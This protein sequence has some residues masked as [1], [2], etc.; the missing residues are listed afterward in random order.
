MPRRPAVHVTHRASGDWAVIREGSDRASSLHPTQ[1]AAA[2]QA[3]GLARRAE[4]ELIIHDR[5]NRIRERS[6]YGN[7]PFPPRDKD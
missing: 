2:D 5:D 1:S 7:D 6:S 3:R 4:T